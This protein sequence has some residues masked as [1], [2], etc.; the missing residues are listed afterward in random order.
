MV[1]LVVDFYATEKLL[2]PKQ[3]TKGVPDDVLQ[4]IKPKIRRSSRSPEGILTAP[5]NP[6]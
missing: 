1:K 6:A 5:F 3:H 2:N 4:S